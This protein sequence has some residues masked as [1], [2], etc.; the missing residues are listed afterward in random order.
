MKLEVLISCIKLLIAINIIRYL[1]SDTKQLYYMIR[2]SAPQQG[3]SKVFIRTKFSILFYTLK[4]IMCIMYGLFLI[5]LL[6]N[7]TDSMVISPG[8][9]RT[10]RHLTILYVSL[11]IIELPFDLKYLVEDEVYNT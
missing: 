4:P 3:D 8:M 9:L 10:L 2:I 7:T 5:V 1:I 11:N 6:V